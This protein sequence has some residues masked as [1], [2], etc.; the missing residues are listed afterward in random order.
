M[1]D[2][3][4][5]LTICVLGGLEEDKAAQWI[6]SR[7]RENDWAFLDVIHSNCQGETNSLDEKI[8]G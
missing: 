7:R 8:G 5:T 2:V 6:M 4:T 1:S 3:S